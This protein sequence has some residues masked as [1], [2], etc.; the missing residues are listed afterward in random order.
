MIDSIFQVGTIISIVI[1]FGVLIAVIK[2][3][4]KALQGQ[5]LVRT[6]MGGTK[7][8]FNG[9]F[10]VPV[11]HKLEVMDITLKTIVIARTGR[12]GLVCKDNM[13][14]DIKV[15]FFLRVNQTIEDVKQV[16]QSI[17]SQRASNQESLE[18]LFDAKFSEALKTVGK[19]FEFVGLYT[20]RDQFKQ[21]ILNIIGTDLNGYVLDDCAIDYLEQTPRTELDEN[22]ILDAE[23]IKKII[24]LTSAQK[25]QANQI[26]REKEKTLTKQDVEARETI[27]ELERQ[28]A[29]AEA[30][31]K[32]E[33]ESVQAREEAETAK[34]KEEERLKADRARIRTEE[35]LSVAEENKLREI[36]VAAK[37]KE[38]TEA[39]ESEKVDRA[40]LLEL[41]DK[42]RFVEIARI[43]KEKA[44]EE[45]RKNI[46]DV[47]RERVSIEKTVVEE[48][49]RMKD[50]E[51]YAGAD[52]TKKV[53]ITLAEKEAEEALVKEIKSA[54]ARKQASEHLAKQKLIDAQASENAAIHEAQAKKTLAEA[55][56]AEAAAIGMSEA[57]VME[58]KAAASEK[59]GDAAASI[60]EME[61]MAEAKGIREKG[62][63][64]AEADEKL[65]NVAA[66]VALEKGQSDA[67]VVE[68]M[69]QSEE[70]RGL[71][72]AKVMAEK[73]T[74]D[75]EGIRQKAEAMKALD[76]SGRSH[77][78][79]KLQLEV[80]KEVEL[81]R[82]KVQEQIALSQAEVIS[83]ALKAANI[84][85]VGGETMFFDQIVGSITKGKSVDK[86][87]SNSDVLTQV[88][89]T[90]FKGEN[91]ENFKDRLRGFVS[92]F[93]IST[94]DV[95]D[96]S[97]SALILQ[98]AQNASSESDKNIIQSLGVVAKSLGITDDPVSK[99]GL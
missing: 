13:R 2:M 87:M 7:V 23:G 86:L 29:E 57:Q 45:E 47:I 10:I 67:K 90:F 20:G 58:A 55:Q 92:Q 77:E 4:R 14:A 66:R 61:A 74:A 36:L 8:S 69:A 42:E 63:A 49:E 54:E 32:R 85:I 95:K 24:D 19:N 35:E 72:E 28:Q 65:G 31:Q 27:L 5:A 97:I 52:R 40:R 75:A 91:G 9:I 41:T 11:I 1:V 83:E 89:D 39:V 12:E 81:S 93:G 80:D 78:E 43:E 88:K 73:F 98:L 22:N 60:I 38:R 16:A 76:E 6:G 25:I 53:A 96:L 71:A 59:E 56:A 18:L 48:K 3:Y 17:G 82:I 26:E 64:Q 50:I 51:A 21:D 33:I 62:F 99:L 84:E 70:K 46:Q 68:L 15:T 30:K 44:V 37:N 94:E 79:F 34:I